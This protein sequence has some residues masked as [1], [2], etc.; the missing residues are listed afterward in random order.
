MLISEYYLISGE[1]LNVLLQIKKCH[2]LDWW[3][4]AMKRASIWKLLLK[5]LMYSIKKNLFEDKLCSA[6]DR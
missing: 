5:D 2:R 3:F 4:D 6:T 1:S